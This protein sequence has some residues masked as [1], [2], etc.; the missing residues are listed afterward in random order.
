MMCPC[1]FLI[2]TVLKG[3]V[4][5]FMYGDSTGTEQLLSLQHSSSSHKYRAYMSLILIFI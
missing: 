2:I 3:V 4:Y 5:H 1:V